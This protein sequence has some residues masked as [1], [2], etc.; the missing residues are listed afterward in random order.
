MRPAR[1]WAAALF[2][3]TFERSAARED[4]ALAQLEGDVRQAVNRAAAA[5]RQDDLA[6]WSYCPDLTPHT[7]RIQIN[8]RKHSVTRDF[9]FASWE[10][11]DRRL[12]ISPRLPN[13]CFE[14]PRDTPLARRAT[15]VLTAYFRDRE[16]EG[17]D[18]NAKPEDFAAG[19][20]ARLST[21]VVESHAAQRFQEDRER[22]MA[23]L[24]ADE[25]MS[26]ATELEKVGRCLNRRYPGELM[27][28]A[29]REENVAALTSLFANPAKP[30]APLV[31]VGP[32]QVGKTSLI[33]E[34]LHR[35]ITASEPASAPDA[36]EIWLLSPQRLISGMSFV[37]QWE[38]R[39]LAIL[40][41][42]TEHHHILYFDDLLGLYQAGRSRDSD[43]SV[44]HLLKVHLEE[45]PL[46][47]IAETTPA[48][49]GKLQEADRG[50]AD[51]F[52]VHPL[53]EPSE[54]DTLR[55]L[56]RTVQELEANGGCT[57][58]AGTLPLVVSL[59]SR[60][61]RARAFPGKAAESLRHLAAAFAGHPVK[62]G[63][64]YR[65]FSSRTGINPLF[66]D[67]AEPLETASVR[68]FFESR[69]MGQPEAIE[70]MVGAVVMAKA[71]LNDPARPVSSLLFLGPTGVGKTECAKAL[72]EFFFKSADKMV[73]FDMNEYVG[74]DATLR[75]I[76]AFGRP[77]GLL[78]SAVRRNPYTVVLLDEIEKANADVFDLLLQVLGDGR[79][80]DANGLTADFC[81]TIVVLTSNLGAR[82]SRT[83]FGFAAPEATAGGTAY[84][85]AAENFFRPELFNRLDRV[86]AFDELAPAHIRSLAE[87]FVARTI[88]RHGL[89]D[90]RLTVTVAPEVI[91]VLAQRGFS[92]DHGARA[93]RRA[94]EIHL[95]DPLAAALADHP[96]GAPPAALT[97]S[98]P[99][100]AGGPLAVD[101]QPLAVSPRLVPAP[102]PTLPKAEALAAA[103]AAF[104]FLKSI[105]AKLD[106]WHLPDDP[107]APERLYYYRL[108]D[109]R[110]GLRRRAEKL[111]NLAEAVTKPAAPAQRA[112]FLN[113]AQLAAAFGRI[114]AAP[115]P[116]AAMAALVAEAYQPGPLAHQAARVDFATARLGF[117]A[118]QR[119]ESLES[120]EVTTTGTMAPPPEYWDQ[121]A[122][123]LDTDTRPPVMEA[124]AL[125]ATLALFLGT[126]L[127]LDDTGRLNHFHLRLDSAPPVTHLHA[128]GRTLDFR[129]G[130]ILPS[131]T[132]LPHPVYPGGGGMKDE[133]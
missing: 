55:I 115:D 80:T 125:H 92:P 110:N 27:R 28:A 88:G 113:D 114:T 20:G 77:T 83:P 74:P 117:L 72:A 70:A 81:N 99:A 69:I 107:A 34:F 62:R 43:L 22:D 8:L 126:H 87:R 97:V 94:V 78:T 129:T 35:R 42:A 52:H 101:L 12:V 68:A 64:V 39:F 85:E 45:N 61:V 51:L 93:L 48:A 59:Q 57:F 65:Q 63:D 36:P 128:G 40:R 4:R 86:I 5:M 11:L 37:G 76:G 82:S 118:E 105:D 90:R 60:F 111:Q 75:L 98:A 16:R 132:P 14:W 41:F 13:L 2:V 24:A 49:W 17:D 89:S 95:V 32:P 127:V 23:A 120:A 58:E 3:E 100:T 109:L 104:G 26:G 124:H 119:F 96:P 10:A 71:R 38:E 103:T 30:P 15:E 25:K 6:Y 67:S 123:F 9:F 79:L 102:A 46:G 47:V 31:L 44:G 73:R 54:Q 122:G 112:L 130:V 106:A 7:L 66:L 116:A 33:H 1:Y 19:P 29:Y 91:A 84:R 50:F 56:V 131:A 121:L 133:G 18:R 53:R 108:R 21:L